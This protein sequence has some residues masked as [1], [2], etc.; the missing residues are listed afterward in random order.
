MY[1]IASTC[2]GVH[3]PCSATVERDNPI[4]HAAASTHFETG[5]EFDSSARE[6]VVNTCKELL[7]KLEDIR[8]SVLHLQYSLHAGDLGDVAVESSERARKL[9]AWNQGGLFSAEVSTGVLEGALQ[10]VF[11]AGFPDTTDGICEIEPEESFN[12]SPDGGEPD[13]E[14]SITAG[15]VGHI[16]VDAITADADPLSGADATPSCI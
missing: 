2:I 12:K 14:D 8:T 16:G 10:N 6:V 11:N 15:P 7:A 5:L 13:Q 3:V 1:D 9:W 4:E